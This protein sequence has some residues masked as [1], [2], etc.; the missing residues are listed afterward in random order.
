M[1]Q[2]LQPPLSPAV[3][4]HH[5]LS[6]H[7]D[8]T[9]T[10]THTHTHTQTGALASHTNLAWFAGFS[11]SPS[12]AQLPHKTPNLPKVSHKW[13]HPKREKLPSVWM[14]A[15]H[16]CNGLANTCKCPSLSFI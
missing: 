10:H 5:L 9:H 3:P 13:L 8:N 16:Y 4:A 2:Q 6:L 11:S 12:Q 15:V 7:K 14:D 1:S